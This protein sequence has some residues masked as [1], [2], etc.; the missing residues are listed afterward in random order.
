MTSRETDHERAAEREGGG[1][2][3][4]IL[5][6]HFRVARKV[7]QP[8]RGVHDR[9]ERVGRVVEQFVERESRAIDLASAV[10][11]V[12]RARGN[13]YEW[14]PHTQGNPIGDSELYRQLRL[15]LFLM[16]EEG[17]RQR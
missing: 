1:L 2:E 15:A 8:A 11:V 17:C 7:V 9:S 13:P 6:L 12:G 5:C 10:G 16:H 4:P 14:H 3:E